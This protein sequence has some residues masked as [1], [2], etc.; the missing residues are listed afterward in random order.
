ME[1]NLSIK[2][3]YGFCLTNPQAIEDFHGSLFKADIDTGI[4]TV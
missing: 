3:P 4:N 2:K 1:F